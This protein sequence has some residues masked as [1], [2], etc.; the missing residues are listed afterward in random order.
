MKPFTQ[1]VR[2]E[3]VGELIDL[4]VEY[5]PETQSMARM[6]LEGIAAIHN[7]LCKHPFAYLADE[8]GM[9]KTYQALGLVALLWNEMPDARIL[10]ISPRQNLQVKWHEDYR[11]FFASNYR[12]K[13]GFG[14]DRAASLL[15][16]QPVHRPVLFHNLRS[17]TPTI[18]MPERIAPFVRLTSFT[19]PIY[20]TYRDL[21]DMDDLWNRTSKRLR[22]W[23]L[24]KGKRPHALS[25]SDASEQLNLAF[26]D[27][28]NAK[29]TEEAGERPYFD[30]VVVDEAQCLRNPKNQ[31][32]RVLFTALRHQVNKWLFMSATPAH[33]GPDDL[34]T[35]VNHYPDSGKVLDPNLV[36]DLPAMQE[37]LRAFLVRRP[38]RYLAGSPPTKIG[39]DQYRNHDYRGWG[40]RDDQMS[41]LGTLS[42]GLVQKG[43]VKVLQGR[44]NRYRIGFLSS[45]ESLQSSIRAT[46]PPLT[47]DGDPQEERASGDWQ[48]DRTD[49]G[50]KSE[51]PDTDF[52]HRLA[53][54]FEKRFD[55]TLP[56][57]KVDS[58]VDR[59]APLAFGTKHEVG[60]HKFL[61]FTRRISTVDTL[62]DRLIQRYIQAIEARVRRCWDV[63]RDWS[64]K[65]VRVE[66][67]DDIED[68][69]ESEADP[70]ENSFRIERAKK[71]WL[72]RY[73]Q[74]F[75]ASGR[76]A[77]FF[78][79]AWLRRLCYAGGVDPA[80]AAAKLPDELWAE[81]WTHASRSAGPRRQQYRANRLRYLAVQAIGRFPE[82]F[83][84]DVE[85]A[86]P[87]RIAY[88]AAL[89][90]HLHRATPDK[91]PHRAPELFTQ[92][93]LW[94]AW[95]HR[96]PNGRLAL[97]AAQLRDVGA[98]VSEDALC[99]RLCRRQVVRTLL[100][101][102]FLLTDTLLDLYFAD[103]QSEH[104]T[105]AFAECFLDWLESAD[106]GAGQIR[107][108]C[109]Q[110]ISRLRLIVDGCLEGAGQD[111]R[112]LARNE[113]WPQL[114]N[115]MP[116]IGVIGGSGAHRL[117]TRQFRTPSLPRVI[118]CTDTLKE[119]VDLHLFCDRVL[120]YGVAWTSGDL[121]QRVG[122]VD[123]FFSQ[124]ER[125]LQQGRPP[126]VELHVG[127]PHVVASLDR[128]Q[129]ERVIERQKRAELLM[130]SPL[131]SAL[132]ESKE[133]V[134]G[135]TNPREKGHELGPFS[136]PPN[137]FPRHGR[138]V[139][140]VSQQEARKSA[141]HYR[142]WYAQ[143]KNAVEDRG[144]RI[145][146]GDQRPVRV[147]TLYGKT[148]QHDLEWRYDATI[149]R[150]VLTLSDIP[151][152]NDAVFSDGMRRRLIGRTR[153][154]ESFLR[155]LVPNPEE[156]TDDSLIVRT[157]AALKG[158]FPLSS[159]NGAA[160]WEGTL[161]SMAIGR[162][163]RVS[164]NEFRA[165]MPRGGREQRIT[166]YA[167]MGGV[168]VRS[169]VAPLDD[170]E[171]RREW[172]G[173]P[174]A[175][176]VRDWALDRTN[177]L[178]LGYLEVDNRDRLVFGIRVLHGELSEKA[179]RQLVNEVA[180]RADAWEA[181]LTGADRR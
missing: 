97:P 134:V 38:R 82:V 167:Y 149:G 46:I 137:Q 83:G 101:Q 34:P 159:V 178:A 24:F 53:S 25:N 79:D 176:N 23:G 98:A 181:A 5:D 105:N 7:I 177:D 124:I 174:T 4:T 170:L 29:L 32:N 90:K 11:R 91:D 31:T 142:F 45:F 43:L 169:V 106:P 110:W 118:V 73:R 6:Q 165:T 35:I 96:F 113:S 99:R 54:S 117:A 84:L 145:S 3:N 57:P 175:E 121:E 162:V 87:W 33:G 66:E 122:R 172:G 86:T 72:Y 131:A 161:A 9:G 27:A 129:V 151:W 104:D 152:K 2:P 40:V 108:D 147:A 18:G 157:V 63:P 62:R 132:H 81:S 103:E 1:P 70:G 114:Y 68:P 112:E 80:N 42:M 37:S 111:W 20:L 166:L 94:T 148:E 16:S 55:M 30:L 10:F 125:R 120:H 107:H 160:Y 39:K 155:L 163:E 14:D 154:V 92:S 76:N 109:V 100:T 173:A 60:G 123:R 56:H 52:I 150:Y 88:E 47:S 168:R 156:G 136:C 21:G 127:Y 89:H 69:K 164:S 144:W 65:S 133:I 50:T 67:S 15:F 13:Q 77:L 71:G 44:S 171:H 135:A 115:P 116:V 139:V 48:L 102:T 49:I 93:T 146:P 26:A 179:R 140:I 74:T 51:A 41:V 138:P 95:D 22:S 130:D 158:Q 61:I 8:V 17:W 78:E 36:Q 12:R 59:V 28:L 128:V 143:F 85:N 180:W 19:R 119:G 64:I 153:R 75:R 58:V 141:D 126:D